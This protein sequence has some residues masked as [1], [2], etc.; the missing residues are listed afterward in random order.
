MGSFC[1]FT[2]DGFDCTDECAL[3]IFDGCTGTCAL[4]SLA[5]HMEGTYEVLRALR[6]DARAKAGEAGHEG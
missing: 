3:Y 2:E 6:T 4:A 1:P 5:L